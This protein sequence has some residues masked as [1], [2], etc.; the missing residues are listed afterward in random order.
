MGATVQSGQLTVLGVAIPV[1]LFWIGERNF[2]GS[3]AIVLWTLFATFMLA[4][5]PFGDQFRRWAIAY[6]ITFFWRKLRGDEMTRINGVAGLEM[7]TIAALAVSVCLLL[8]VIPFP[9]TARSAARDQ[10]TDLS[11]SFVELLEPL[12]DAFCEPLKNGHFRKKVT[13]RTQNTFERLRHIEKH[14]ADA[15][16]EP[17]CFD[18]LRRGRLIVFAEHMRMCLRCL[19]ILVNLRNQRAPHKATTRFHNEWQGVEQA[20]ND[21]IR[22]LGDYAC[23]RAV[24]DAALDVSI[25]NLRGAM[26]AWHMDRSYGVIDTDGAT[27]PVSRE[28][29]TNG[30]G[31]VILEGSQAP[32]V[33]AGEEQRVKDTFSFQ[34]DYLYHLMER[35]IHDI[36]R[37]VP[38]VSSV[39]PGHSI[40]T[41]H[42]VLEEVRASQPREAGRTTEGTPMDANEK[43][44]VFKK[45]GFWASFPRTMPSVKLTKERLRYTAKTVFPVWYDRAICTH[46]YTHTLILSPSCTH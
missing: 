45:Y 1:L 12:S 31:E 9:R 27:P 15:W 21:V 4:F 32:R 44:S 34:M 33:G 26:T 7:L 14:L 19:H 10:L 22:L 35:Y 38:F 39:I 25:G 46:I 40:V 11:D 16:Y 24:D 37:P 18:P 6:T 3:I 43:D 42:A 20:V 13:S 17:A 29:S 28:Q 23:G 30:F 2:D 36:G 41:S 5:L 8:S